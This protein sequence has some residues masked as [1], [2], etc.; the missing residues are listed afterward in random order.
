MAMR[1]LVTGATGF[2]GGVLC[3]VLARAGYVVRAALRS[4]SSL[5]GHVREKVAVGPI[6]GATDW[7]D[8]LQGVDAV[9]HLA[10][11]VHILNARAGDTGYMETNARGTIR[12]AQ[13]SAEAGVRRLVFLSSIK[14]N[15]EESGSR[16]YTAADEPQPRDA[17]GESKWAAETGL[18]QIAATTRMEVTS[19]RSPL[20]YGPGVRAN[21]LR[22]MVWVDK[23]RPLPLGAV[24]NQ[25]SLVNVWNLCDLL[26][27]AL[28]HP[29]AAGRTLMVS[30]GRDV[31]TR[32]LILAI[33]TAMNRRA[34]LWP[35]PVS[36][37]RLAGAL[38]GRAAE[39]ARLCGSLT[40]D[41]TATR[42]DLQWWPPVA[43]E[44][45]LTRTV[46]WY[47]DT[48]AQRVA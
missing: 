41:S 45:A 44:E 23:R 27:R 6:D 5:P 47:L 28:E 4:D 31:S 12:L 46:R 18:R 1:V 36:M 11:R 48:E 22:L 19:V 16:P 17:Y 32:E 42:R 10:A 7:T 8:A 34:R 13:A 2:V 30:D 3:E 40:V 33:A 14:V 39:V 15:G 43:F 38:T 25:R 37:L 20:V 21:F 29:Q 9:L 26:V 35:V 24:T